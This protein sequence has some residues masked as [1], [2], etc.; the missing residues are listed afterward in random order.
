MNKKNWYSKK[1]VVYTFDPNTSYSSEEKRG[2]VNEYTKKRDAL[3]L[4]YINN[5]IQKL[6]KK[7]KEFSFH[8]F[9][10]YCINEGKEKIFLRFRVYGNADVIKTVQEYE[11]KNKGKHGIVV[12]EEPFNFQI[13]KANI[14]Q[15]E[16]EAKCATLVYEGISRFVIKVSRS[17]FQISNMDNLIPHFNHLFLNAL[18]RNIV[19]EY[20]DHKNCIIE[21]MKILTN[22]GSDKSFDWIDANCRDEIMIVRE[23][24]KHLDPILQRMVSKAQS[25]S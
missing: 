10:Y 19:Q 1:L 8:F 4:E 18:G 14:F 17:T 11:D 24:L 12:E 13:A 22:N 25:S 20:Y 6:E 21:R 23:C 3:V 15:S 16:D 5:L 9:R 2:I 7:K